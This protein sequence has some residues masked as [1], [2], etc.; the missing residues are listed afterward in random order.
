MTISSAYKKFSPFMPVKDSY[1]SLT[2]EHHNFSLDKRYIRECLEN[3]R[4]SKEN[5]VV[6]NVHV[7]ENG[8]ARLKKFHFLRRITSS[9][10][11]FLARSL[12]TYVKADKNLPSAT[13][14]HKRGVNFF[15]LTWASEKI[16][17]DRGS[18]TLFLPSI[19]IDYR[20]DVFLRNMVAMEAFMMWKTR[21]FTCYADLMDRLIDTPSDVAV[22]KRYGIITS[23]LGCDKEISNLWNG[24]RRSIW[25]STYEPIDQTIKDVNGYY[26]SRYGVLLGEF[27]QEH[28][29][30][31][32]RALSVVAACT[33]LVLAFLQT[34]F[35]YYQWR[36]PG[37]HNKH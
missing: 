2:I 3:F 6:V 28:F 35:S 17:F 4:I 37:H 18:S 21:V 23:D 30:N 25:R 16:R 13:E 8:M 7:E 10:R 34:L 33:L 26:R 12:K 11:D 20:T 29:S 24:I 32:W 22:L 1:Q 27:L 36:P 19:E 9:F 14:L 15:A 31:P 5:S